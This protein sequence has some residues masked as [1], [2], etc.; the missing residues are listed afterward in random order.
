MPCYVPW[1]YNAGTG[2]E[3]RCPHDRRIGKIG[4]KLG[5]KNIFL[6]TETAEDYF[7]K[8]GYEFLPREQAPESIRQSSEFRHACPASAIL[9]QKEI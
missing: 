7:L 2:N 6:L 9:M 4:E 8:K 1:L 5:I 3:N